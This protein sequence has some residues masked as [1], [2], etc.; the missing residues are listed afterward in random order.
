MLRFRGGNHP[1]LGSR[2][3]EEF[4]LEGVRLYQVGVSAKG[5]FE[6]LFI[7]G[8]LFSGPGYASN[9]STRT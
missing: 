2:P 9:L 6:A 5:A 7:R 3:G 8:A 1:P 4:L